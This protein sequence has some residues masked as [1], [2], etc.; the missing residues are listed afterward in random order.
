[1]DFISYL[2][3]NYTSENFNLFQNLSLDKS[4]GLDNM[5]IEKY[6][7]KFYK[8][9]DEIYN[10]IKDRTF[11]F[12]PFKLVYVY[13]R[14]G[15]LRKISIL[16]IRDKFLDR[17]TFDFLS[18]NKKN[19]SI[20]NISNSI[21]NSIKNGKVYFLRCDIKDFFST[22]NHNILL[23]KIKSFYDDNLIS[24]IES[25]LSTPTF[26]KY[27]AI[28]LK[29]NFGENWDRIKKY[30]NE[31]GVPQGSAISQALSNIYLEDFDKIINE[32][33]MKNEIHFYRYC[34]DICILSD[35]WNTIDSVKELVISELKKLE[36]SIN[37]DKLSSG[38]VTEGFDYLGFKHNFG[39]IGISINSIHFIKENF[40]KYYNRKLLIFSNTS[41]KMKAS[42][43]ESLKRWIKFALP[44]NNAI[45]GFNPEWFFCFNDNAY[46]LSR[47]L[48]I[49][50]NY[51]QIKE[52]EIWL[53]RLNKYYCL[54]VCE[55]LNLTP[56]VIE[57]ESLYNWFFKYKK[58]YYNTLIKAYRNYC[59]STI[60]LSI[61][62]KVMKFIPSVDETYE[63]YIDNDDVNQEIMSENVDEFDIFDINDLDDWIQVPSQRR[64]L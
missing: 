57:L 6:L 15:K 25:F 28:F 46:G 43:S 54:K 33:A 36:L 26:P 62:I 4:I 51:H 53:G 17:I 31:I 12:I 27:E 5:T 18:L 49:V 48:S 52:L 61:P 24:L 29:Q 20:H 45:R 2:E 55:K 32:F 63:N 10:S 16:S 7:N 59:I 60:N 14:N 9:Y 41:S 21:Y 39:S 13:K 35:N 3:K 23:S 50:N 22:I 1:M 40:I 38:S 58:N 37:S 44:L 19:Y 47:H 34:D 11:K 30:S 8:I 64:Y 42:K 56:V